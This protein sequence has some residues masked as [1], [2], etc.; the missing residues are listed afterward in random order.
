M[1]NV[2]EIRKDFPILKTK[3]NS[4]NDLIYF[5]N[6]AIVQIKSD[7]SP[8][9][10][11]DLLSEKLIRSRIVENYPEYGI[12]S[13][14]TEDNLVRLDKD[15]VWIVDPIDGTKDYVNKTIFKAVGILAVLLEFFGEIVVFYNHFKF[16]S[17]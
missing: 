10:Q 16:S 2:N 1:F 11:A 4:G 8:V 12:L 6:S 17:S 13:E 15:Y 7:D 3:T 14:E 9:T 5:D